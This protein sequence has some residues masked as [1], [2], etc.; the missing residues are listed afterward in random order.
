MAID[1]S[2]ER[3]ITL[4]QATE[5]VPRR[6]RGRKTNLAT[7]YRW[8][9]SGSRGVVLETIQVAGSR[10]T[11]VEALQRFF[12]ALTTVAAEAGVPRFDR[13]QVEARVNA[14]DRDLDRRWEKDGRS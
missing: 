14:A 12:D 4:N 10:C 2:F 5:L 9:K 11:S 1:I 6:R 3:L 8:S 13:R 7:V